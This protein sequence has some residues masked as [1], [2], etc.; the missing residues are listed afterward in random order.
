MMASCGGAD[1]QT[2]ELV[3]KLGSSYDLDGQEVE[4][5][6]YLSVPRSVLVM[7][8][9]ITLGLHNTAGQSDG[10]LAR[11][12]VK[13][14]KGANH[15]YIP[16]KYSGS[17]VE[18]YDADGNEHGYLTRVTI[19]GTVRYTN[20]NWDRRIK[21]YLDGAP[22]NEDDLSLGQARELKA[23]EER[24]KSQNGGPNDYTFEILVDTITVP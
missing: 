19:K 4:M 3:G 17:D 8:D 16:E 10:E 21:E 23:V 14:G 7:N 2:K 13:F 22:V 1:K 15:Y 20:K 18:I 12:K 5:T 24:R 11:L 6:G 9:V